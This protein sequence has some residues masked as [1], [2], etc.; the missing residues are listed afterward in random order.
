MKARFDP[1]S[2]SSAK[3]K[4]TKTGT[5]FAVSRIFAG[6]NKARKFNF[7][8]IRD[9]LVISLDVVVNDSANMEEPDS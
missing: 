3:P 2:Y 4:S 9:M 6:L 5:C 1:T 7:Q 8:I